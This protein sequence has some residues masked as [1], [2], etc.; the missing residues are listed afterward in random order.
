MFS[1]SYIREMQVDAARA[2]AK[3]RKVP[4]VVWPEDVQ[5]G[6]KLLASFPFLGDYIPKGWRRAETYLVDAT[7]FGADYESA[8]TVDEFL[9]HVLG[10]TKSEQGSAWGVYEAGQFQVIVARYVKDPSEKRNRRE[11]GDEE[12]DLVTRRNW[13]PCSIATAEEGA[14]TA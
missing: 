2:A 1:G 3:E 11:T 14:H 9:A 6:V 8:L 10:C 13:T 5:L 7:G 12:L 4:F